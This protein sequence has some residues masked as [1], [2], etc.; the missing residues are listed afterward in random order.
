[1]KNIISLCIALLMSTG[2]YAQQFEQWVRKWIEDSPNA[3]ESVEQ[4]YLKN[5]SQIC[6]EILD[7]YGSNDLGVANFYADL[8]IAS[9]QKYTRKELHDLFHT[10][11]D[12][13]KAMIHFKD[14]SY[15]ESIQRYFGS[16]SYVDEKEGNKRSCELALEK[17]GAFEMVILKFEFH[18]TSAKAGKLAKNHDQNRKLRSEDTT[19][20]A[21]SLLSF[22]QDIRGVLNQAQGK[23]AFKDLLTAADD[24]FANI[25]STQQENDYFLVKPNALNPQAPEPHQIIHDKGQMRIELHLRFVELY[26]AVGWQFDDEVNQGLNAILKEDWEITKKVNGEWTAVLKNGQKHKRIVKRQKNNR[27]YLVIEVIKKPFRS[28]IAQYPQLLEGNCVAGNCVEGAGKFIFQENDLYTV[29]YQGDFKNGLYEGIGFVYLKYLSKEGI[30]SFDLDHFTNKNERLL[31]IGHYR[32]GKRYGK[33]IAY[34]YAKYKD[35][36]INFRKESEYFQEGESTGVFSYI[37]QDYEADSLLSEELCSFVYYQPNT[38]TSFKIVQP[39]TTAYGNCISGSCQNGFGTLKIEGLGV[40]E[41]EFLNGKAQ[42]LGILK[43]PTGE[44]K[45]FASHQGIPQYLRTLKLPA[46]VSRLAAAERHVW[47]LANDDCLEGNC[48]DGEGLRLRISADRFR[49][50]NVPYRGYVRTTFK[51]GIATGKFKIFSL[52]GPEITVEGIFEKGAFEGEIVVQWAREDTPRYEYYQSGRKVTKDGQ[53]YAEFLLEQEKK[54]KESYERRRQAAIAE[55]RA[56]RE[57]RAAEARTKRATKAQSQPVRRSSYCNN[58]KGTGSS[59]EEVVTQDCTITY[60]YTFSNGKYYQTSTH[61]RDVVNGGYT[62]CPVCRGDGRI[63]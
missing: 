52:W 60:D 4:E 54:W 40:F 12:K 9:S 43:L 34:A 62:T 25:I 16:V 24:D 5:G 42:G 33:G 45:Y 48:Y 53:D 18:G 39:F 11:K 30:I 47:L 21:P 35:P 8:E 17:R 1:M 19:I 56:E 37:F 63:N 61:C 15:H 59:Y 28:L 27:D 7:T 29:S 22:N 49:K 55:G 36:L 13:L 26:G 32:Q 23:A 50:Y 41:G 38:K 51:Q 46:G 44:W 10:H 2:C 14:W 31:F 57:R 3:F 20:L 58:C 6:G